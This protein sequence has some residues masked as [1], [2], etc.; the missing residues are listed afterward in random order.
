[1]RIDLVQTDGPSGSLRIARCRSLSPHRLELKVI[2]VNGD[3]GGNAMCAQSQHNDRR[4]YSHNHKGLG[5]R[6]CGQ[7]L[8]AGSIT[9]AIQALARWRTGKERGNVAK[10]RNGEG[11][12]TGLNERS[13]S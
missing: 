1:M 11:V 7:K 8:S 12:A 2:V 6:Q 5:C 9:K 10:E 3:K 4:Y 13:P